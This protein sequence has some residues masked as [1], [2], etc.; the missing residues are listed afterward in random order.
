MSKDGGKSNGKTI[1]L[2]SDYHSNQ[3]LICDI[4]F[5]AHDNPYKQIILI[6]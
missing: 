3:N 1:L 2:F 6:L 4:K 5:M